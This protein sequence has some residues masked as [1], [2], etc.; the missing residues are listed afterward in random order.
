MNNTAALIAQ[1]EPTAVAPQSAS[2]GQFL[3]ADLTGNGVDDL[4]WRQPVPGSFA[5]WQMSGAT[6]QSRSP[7]YPANSTFTLVATG[8]FFGAGKPD[9]LV[10]A[11]TDSIWMWV[12]GGGGFA[13]QRV[14]SMPRGWQIIGAGD[15]D[16]DGKSDLIFRNVSNTGGNGGIAYWRM[17]GSTVIYRSPLIAMSPAYHEAAIGDFNGDGRIDILWTNGS[18][19]VVWLSTGSGFSEANLGNYPAGWQLLGCGDVNGDAKCDLLWYNSTASRL[20]YW[21]VDG[22]T[23]TYKSSAFDSPPSYTPVT[24]G[25]FNGDG[26]IDIV[27]ANNYYLLMWRGTGSGFNASTF[28]AYPAT[29]FVAPPPPGN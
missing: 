13:N 19:L 2:A 6:V 28:S 22:A 27:W 4:L 16:G 15:V 29:W 10:W 25:D 11:N 14:D 9:D 8:R 17:N 5:Y 21:L 24:I 3:R 1:F 20:A 26:K 12:P 23:V 7:G 18:S